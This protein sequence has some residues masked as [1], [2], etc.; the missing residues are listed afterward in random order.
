ML[1]AMTDEAVE[2]RIHHEATKNTKK[3]IN[4]VPREA[5]SFPSRVLRGFVVKFLALG[6]CKAADRCHHTCR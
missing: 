5:H 4:G 6:R 3:A 1:L 2:A